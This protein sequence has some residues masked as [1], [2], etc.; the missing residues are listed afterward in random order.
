MTMKYGTR[1]MIPGN[2]WMSM[3]TNI[4]PLRPANW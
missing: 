4:A 2:I 1:M 3:K